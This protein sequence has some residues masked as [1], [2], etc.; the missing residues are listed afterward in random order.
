M[1]EYTLN[2]IERQLSARLDEASLARVGR[3]TP[4]TLHQPSARTPF[5][6]TDSAIVSLFSKGMAVM[7]RELRDLILAAEASLHDLDE[8]EE[9]MKVVHA[10]A[11]LEEGIISAEQDEL[12]A[13]LWT[14]L[15]GNRRELRQYASRLKL[16]SQVAECRKHA[17]AHV[18]GTLQTLQRMSADLEVL[19]ARVKEPA[20]VGDDAIPVEVH[21]RSIKQGVDRLSEDRTRARTMQSALYA[22]GGED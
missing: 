20:L 12:L 18:S 10:V 4:P 7:E 3:K 1:S 13:Q 9:T 21:I 6:D 22:A 11:S 16:L 5:T 15:G 17:L 14:M 19:R 8:L 2:L